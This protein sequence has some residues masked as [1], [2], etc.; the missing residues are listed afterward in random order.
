MD[1]IKSKAVWG[2]LKKFLMDKEPFKPFSNPSSDLFVKSEYTT[3]TTLLSLPNFP[4][5]GIKLL[6]EE[7]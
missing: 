7:R 6:Q 3:D 1:S 2:K 4:N 5:F